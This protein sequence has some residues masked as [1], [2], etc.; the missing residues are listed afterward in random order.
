MERASIIQPLV[1]KAALI[2]SDFHH[3]SERD[4]EF[5]ARTAR[6]FGCNIHFNAGDTPDYFLGHPL[7]D[8]LENY[9]LLVKNFN[10]STNPEDYQMP[11]NWH[12][13]TENGEGKLFGNNFLHFRYHLHTTVPGIEPGERLASFIVIHDPIQSRLI[14]TTAGSI[15]KGKD[16]YLLELTH[17]AKQKAE[18]IVQK[19]MEELGIEEDAWLNYLIFGHFHHVLIY[20]WEGVRFLDPA[21]WGGEKAEEGKPRMCASVLIPGPNFFIPISLTENFKQVVNPEDRADTLRELLGCK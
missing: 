17:L 20:S 10:R 2:S 12:L 5:L 11:A 14:G 18:Q 6:A 13:L 19:H 4:L 16:C 3:C 7:F 15:R 9:F 1:I 21:P 8:G